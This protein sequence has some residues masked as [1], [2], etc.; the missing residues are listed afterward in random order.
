[1]VV[2]LFPLPE[3]IDRLVH[4]DLIILDT[5][6]D[7]DQALEFGIWISLTIFVWKHWNL[8]EQ[9]HLFKKKVNIYN[10][11]YAGLHTNILGRGSALD[12]LESLCMSPV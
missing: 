10:I 8:R 3:K 6:L 12:F 2:A 5:I 7:V 11:Q 9:K 1:M 4:T